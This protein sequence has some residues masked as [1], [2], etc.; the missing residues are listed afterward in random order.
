MP[1]T[2]EEEVIVRLTADNKQLK[3]KL[4]ESESAAN[5]A[6]GGIK[7]AA[8]ALGGIFAG[9]AL[10][11]SLR[12]TSAEMDKI[13]KTASRLGIAT[14]KLSGLQFAAEQSGVAVDTLNMALQRQ[15]RRIAEAAQGTGEAVKAIDELGLSAEHLNSLSPDEQMNEIADAME[16]VTN[17][18]DK[19]RLSMKL[20]DS[21]GVALVNMLKG[22]SAALQAYHRD[23]VALGIAMD[24]SMIRKVEAAND[25]NNRLSKSFSVVGKVL[26]VQLAP[27]IIFAA[28]SIVE[29]IREFQLGAKS[30]DIFGTII[31]GVARGFIISFNAM[32]T[33]IDGY[34]VAW[35]GAMLL[36]E[37]TK[38][39]FNLESDI[40]A[41]RQAFE[42]MAVIAEESSLTLIESIMGT[43]QATLNL[44]ASIAEINAKFA[45]V[46]VTGADA[47]VTIKDSTE[48]ADEAIKATGDTI[49]SSITSGFRQAMDGALDFKDLIGAMVKDVVAQLIKILVVQKAIGA[50]FGTDTGAISA[51]AGTV[52][53]AGAAA[54]GGIIKKSGSYLVG[55][56]GPEI[57]TLP[58]NSNVIPNGGDA[59]S[60]ASASTV[61]NIINNSNSEVS[62]QEDENGLTVLI[63]A[64]SN[65]IAS[66]ITRR[67]NPV[68]GAVQQMINQGR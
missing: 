61:V 29:L 14:D 1:V 33:A 38:A 18:S 43:D 20:W 40:S 49:G 3:V 48:D 19:V 6:L 37:E 58:A 35:S 25:A 15:T 21:E 32:Q 51:S 17:Q 54:T 64:V 39:F 30:S 45:K 8:V 11:N 7:K 56:D 23:A 62:A 22:G 16:N 63:E 24:E 66:G 44:L 52:S 59:T 28:N 10:I 57:V 31:E 36:L 9:R 46:K 13:G 26:N 60:S 4:A 42:Q 55:E 41:A 2:T 53:V 27:Y 5:K 50:I 68:S 47:M 65:S 34:R 12:S 67:T